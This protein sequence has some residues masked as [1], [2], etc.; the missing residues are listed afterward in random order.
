MPKAEKGSAKDIA[1]RMKAKG[2]QKL[3]FFCQM[4][5]KQ[6]RDENGFKCHL[7]SDSHLRN[8]QSFCSNSSGMLDQFSSEFEKNYLDTLYRRHRTKKMNANNVY[9][10]VIQDKEHV[11]MNATKWGTL[12]DFVQYLGKAGKCVVEETERG[13]YITF[14]E[15][16]PEILA[17]QENYK[18]RV[19]AEKREEKKLAKRMEMQ[20]VEAAKMMDRAGF[21]VQVEASNLKRT[22]EDAPIALTFG[23]TGTSTRI[24]S[25]DATKKKKKT[26][27]SLAKGKSVFGDDTDTDNSN[28]NDDNN[29]EGD[30]DKYLQENVNKPIH[31]TRMN[32]QSFE[33][34]RKRKR[35]HDETGDRIQSKRIHMNNASISSSSPLPVQIEK[36]NHSRNDNERTKN[37]IMD[38]NDLED[39]RKKTLDTETYSS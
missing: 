23:G 6:C 29:G 35:N 12:T 36:K 1:N 33:S 4:C 5:N 21:G 19:E 14:I 24:G 30:G 8:M 15:R 34:S 22:D 9:Q 16:N 10:E 13:W 32:D 27:K 38:K 3:R 11:H 2:L 7:T 26:K 39:I 31:E 25:S 20:R 17:Q 37:T 28:D 18:R